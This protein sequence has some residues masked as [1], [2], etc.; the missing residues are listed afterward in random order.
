LDVKKT[1][2]EEILG[3]AYL[4]MDRAFARLDG[5]R[6]KSLTVTLTPKGDRSAKSLK[7]LETAFTAELASQKVR[8]ALSRANQPI[9]EYIVENAVAL[10]QGRAEALASAAPAPTSEELTADQ[11]SEIERLIAEVE[12]EIRDMN[13]KKAHPDPKGV[14]PSWEA[15]Q[16]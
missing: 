5:D 8:W 11:R 1:G 9:R 12:T 7:A 15:Q 14:A 2:L 10:A 16:K 4:M 6:K 13:D 3:A